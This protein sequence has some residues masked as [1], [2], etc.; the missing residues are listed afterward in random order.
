MRQHRIRVAGLDKVKR[1]PAVMSGNRLVPEP[2]DCPIGIAGQ[3]LGRRRKSARRAPSPS[4]Q[5][6]IQVVGLMCYDVC[7]RA[8]PV[9]RAASGAGGSCAAARRSHVLGYLQATPSAWVPHLC[10]TRAYIAQLTHFEGVIRSIGGHRPGR[11]GVLPEGL[12]D[13]GPRFQRRP[14]PKC[15]RGWRRLIHRAVHPCYR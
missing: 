1:S 15:R 9:R 13:A 5:A 3:L 11:A 7:E 4:G 2:D 14:A 8:L 10:A 6:P 12:R